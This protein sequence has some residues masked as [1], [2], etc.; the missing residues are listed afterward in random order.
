[1]PMKNKFLVLA[2]ILSMALLVSCRSAD[3]VSVSTVIDGDTIRIS[4]DISVRYL[5]IDTPETGEPYYHQARDYNATLLRWKNVT[6]QIDTTD[7]DVHSRLLRYVYADKVLVNAEL[8]KQGYAL[9]YARNKFP[10][11][12]YY[13]VFKNALDD[14]VRLKKGIWSQKSH[15]KL[16][17]KGDY[18][19][20]SSVQNK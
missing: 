9:V 13:D 10:D 2:V 12:K 5:G 8:V 14:A 11:N 17:N 20:P 18:Y 16:A 6:L 15:P 7:K 4:G 1:M 3:S 19:L